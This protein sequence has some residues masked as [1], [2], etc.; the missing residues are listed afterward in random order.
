MM[1]ACLY[2]TGIPCLIAVLLLSG[3]WDLQEIEERGLV[4]GL[5][6]DLTDEE[7]DPENMETY[8][9]WKKKGEPDR[10]RLT[11]QVAVPTQQGG[12]GQ[13][14]T[15]SQPYFN[16]S[17]V[18]HSVFDALR[19]FSTRSSR[20]FTLDHIKLVAV[21]DNIAAS[22]HFNEGLL[23]F[24]LRDHQMRRRMLFFVTEGE[25]S[26]LLELEGQFNEIPAMK[27]EA[28]S[29]NYSRSNRI[30][31]PF[32]IGT[33]SD[34]IAKE[35]SFI[36]R[37]IKVTKDKD[38]KVAGALL[39]DGKFSKLAGELGEQ[40]TIA[41]NLIVGE[42]QNGI[43]TAP[44]KQ[45]HIA[46]FEIFSADSKIK[47]TIKRDNI[48]FDIHIS[49]TGH[50]GETQY[51]GGN[52]L[53]SKYI[54]EVEEVMKKEIETEVNKVTEKLQKEFKLDPFNLL[55]EIRVKN[56]KMYEKVRRNWDQGEKIFSDVPIRFHIDTKIERIGI[57]GK[58]EQKEG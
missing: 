15:E 53:T 4:I 34:E 2:K 14:E 41:Y 7:V 50:L 6:L 48:S 8:E 37:K 54:K 49:A 28:V 20:T 47:P 36:I 16:M 43:I 27:I 45:G 38:I 9:E 18:S 26:Q 42:H 19:L 12:N 30:P 22:D 31:H 21:S 29:E 44:D 13:S 1:R 11:G 52:P 32:A 40:E 5:A 55:D 56:Y 33:L 46:A 39:F 23:D 17:T 24:F 10:V 58:P 57:S 3:C 35:T 25:A 51:P